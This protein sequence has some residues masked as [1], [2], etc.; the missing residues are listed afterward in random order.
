M[1]AGRELDALVAKHVMHLLDVDKQHG[2]WMFDGGI[3]LPVPNYT[4]SIGYAW[5]VVERMR[6]WHDRGL[7]FKA[8]PVGFRFDYSA[9]FQ[10]RDS[11]QWSANAETAPL[12][13]CL[14][15]LKAV[16]VDP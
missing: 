13:I 14:A 2:Q 3:R 5:D 7:I 16:G 11:E 8:Y 4:T 10:A 6:K 12:A 15:A 1:K 9:V